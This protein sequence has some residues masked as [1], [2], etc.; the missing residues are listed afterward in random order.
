MGDGWLRSYIPIAIGVK[1]RSRERAVRFQELVC[2]SFLLLH[3]GTRFAKNRVEDWMRYSFFAVCSATAREKGSFRIWFL[4]SFAPVV[5]PP[6]LR[7]H[8]F[9]LQFALCYVQQVAL[10]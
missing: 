5:R 6:T 2:P 10:D 1:L 9:G 8:A 4:R 7:F 3:E